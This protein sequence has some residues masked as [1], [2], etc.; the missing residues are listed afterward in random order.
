[1]KIEHVTLYAG[2]LEKEKDFFCRYFGAKA[3]SFITIRR[4][5]FPLVF[6]LLRKTPD[7]R[8]CTLI[9]QKGRN[10]AKR[11]RTMITG[12]FLSKAGR[13]WKH[14]PGGCQRMGTRCSAAR[15]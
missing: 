2:N 13:R 14:G 11:E 15:T 8:L 10:P 9:P 12:L 6:S 1:M 4:R 3:A 5:A 7:W